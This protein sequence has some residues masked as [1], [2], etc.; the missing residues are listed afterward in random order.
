MCYE[1]GMKEPDQLLRLR[2]FILQT[3]ATEVARRTKLARRTLQ[4]IAKG[5]TK[6]SYDTLKKLEKAAGASVQTAV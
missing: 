2:S 6:P 3:G 5:T 4:Y 1:A